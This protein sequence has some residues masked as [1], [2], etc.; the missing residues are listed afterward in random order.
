[1][2][3]RAL[4]PVD[5]LHPYTRRIL[6]R[7]REESFTLPSPS[8]IKSMDK[9]IR[10]LVA[11]NLWNR[12]DIHYW[13]QYN[14]TNIK[15][16]SRIDW[17]SPSTRLLTDNI[18][19][20]YVANGWK[21]SGAPGSAYDTQFRFLDAIKATLNNAHK[22]AI[23]FDSSESTDA[24]T[25]IISGNITNGV[26]RWSAFNTNIQRVNSNLSLG[27]SVN[28]SGTGYKTI[29]RTSATDVVLTS[30]IST[31]NA[32]G[33]STSLATNNEVI[34]ANSTSRGRLGL[35][36]YSAGSAIND[37]YMLLRSIYNEFSASIGLTG[38]A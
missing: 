36:N 15:N 34:S 23:V 14:D 38:F 5:G 18:D 25:G 17:I 32:T 37:K 31:F 4:L 20:S 9:M 7:A 2:R 6:A 27:V 30:G 3:R 12:F 11:E 19:V 24:V 26:D 22:A 16:F 21:F 8:T 1:M 28:L 10:R 13:G 29:S 35:C 33:N